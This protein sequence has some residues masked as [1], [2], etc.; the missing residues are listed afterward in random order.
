MRTKRL[1]LLLAHL[2][3]LGN[4]ATASAPLPEVVG[5]WE[6]GAV[7]LYHLLRVEQTQVEFPRL[8]EILG[9]ADASGYSFHD[10]QKAAGKF[11]VRLDA[12]LL[13]NHRSGLQRPLILFTKQGDEGH[14]IVVRPVGHTGSLVQVLDGDREPVAIDADRLIASRA[15]TGL[16]LVP[17][18][19][20]SLSIAFFATALACLAGFL[21]T[22]PRRS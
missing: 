14:F 17:R 6:C 4:S 22:K 9:P 12:V 15:W 1:G 2:C 19:A 3:L 18:R 8:Q 7:S 10:I 11:G 16:A 20:D 21:I 13:D 5:P